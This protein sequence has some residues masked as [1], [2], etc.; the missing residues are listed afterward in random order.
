MRAAGY[1]FWGRGDRSLKRRNRREGRRKEE[2]VR[3]GTTKR[4]KNMNFRKDERR[5]REGTEGVIQ[6]NA[7]SASSWTK[8]LERFSRA[9]D[10]H[11]PVRTRGRG[12]KAIFSF[13]SCLFFGTNDFGV[14]EQFWSWFGFLCFCFSFV[15]FLERSGSCPAVARD[16]I[17]ITVMLTPL[18][19]A[20]Q[21]SRALATWKAQLGQD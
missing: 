14:L 1:K 10:R 18:L 20:L 19:R 8:A 16:S 13:F 17:T 11:R 6:V 4:K 3:E 5:K 15:L 9:E 2:K 21:W 7:W 12:A